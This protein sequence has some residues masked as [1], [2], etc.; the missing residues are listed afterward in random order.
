MKGGTSGGE[1]ELDDGEVEEE[2][3]EG[4]GSSTFMLTTAFPLFVYVVVG[5]YNISVYRLY[6]CNKTPAAE[7]H[8]ILTPP[9]E[10]PTF[11]PLSI[12]LRFP[13][14][15]QIIELMKELPVQ[16]SRGELLTTPL[17]C[18]SPNK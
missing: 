11:D 4:G 5:I 1:E 13:A 6:L 3:A 17:F 8:P 12:S 10:P 7:V 18:L 15:F 9:V 16:L 14:G 2:E